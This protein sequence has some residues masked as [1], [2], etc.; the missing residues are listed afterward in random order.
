MIFCI[1]HFIYQKVINAI[2]LGIVHLDAFYPFV[3]G[4]AFHQA[5]I[6]LPLLLKCLTEVW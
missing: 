3:Q 4:G 6:R 2:R 1:R 5:Q